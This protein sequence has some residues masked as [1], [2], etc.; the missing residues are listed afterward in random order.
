MRRAL[1]PLIVALSLAVPAEAQTRFAAPH[2][3][4]NA[5][6][7]GSLPEA[8]EEAV[9]KE[10]VQGTPA[11]K[12]SRA[13]MDKFNRRITTGDGRAMRSV[14]AGCA[15]VGPRPGAALRGKANAEEQ[16]FPIKDPAQA[17]AD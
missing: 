15:T 11:N 2:P 13:E 3:Q 8:G 14:C 7:T 6:S 17:P 1:L 12:R 4:P 10:T 5:E 9:E 16:E